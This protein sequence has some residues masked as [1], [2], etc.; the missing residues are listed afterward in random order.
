MDLQQRISSQ[1]HE[2]SGQWIWWVIYINQFT[3]QQIPFCCCTGRKWKPQF[4]T[5]LPARQY[6]KTITCTMC[7]WNLKSQLW[8]LQSW[9]FGSWLHLYKSENL[10]TYS[11]NNFCFLTVSFSRWIQGWSCLR[12]WPHKRNPLPVNSIYTYL[13][14]AALVK[15]ERMWKWLQKLRLNVP[16][17]Q[18]ACH[19]KQP[20]VDGC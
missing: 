18:S 9:D 15:I 7:P 10:L 6:E 12:T 2:C 20:V 4:L 1:W 17:S 19:Q 13:H 3:H 16:L 8:A 11:S 5:S 14:R